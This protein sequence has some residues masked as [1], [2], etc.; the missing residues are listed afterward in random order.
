A[1]YTYDDRTHRTSRVLTTRQSDGVSLQDL[2]YTYDPVNNVMQV[3]DLAQQTVYFAGSV[4]SG[5][6]LFEYDPIY[7]ITK[8]SGREQPGQV[9]YSIGPNGYPDAPIASIP[10]RNDLQAL[11]AYIE[12]YSYDSVGNIL[13]TVHQASGAGWTRTQTYVAGTNRLDRTSMPG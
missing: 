2:N 8:A 7:R 12:S 3:T 13:S 6:Q 5:T 10:G 11:L 4:T 9:G 1:Q